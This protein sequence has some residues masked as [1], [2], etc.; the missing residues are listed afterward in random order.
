MRGFCI[1]LDLPQ[2]CSVTNEASLLVFEM[3][4]SNTYKFGARRMVPDFQAPEMRTR[5]EK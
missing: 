4:V 2:G 1:V 3:E 5:K